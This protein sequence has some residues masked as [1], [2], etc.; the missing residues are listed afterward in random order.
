MTGLAH[1]IRFHVVFV[2]LSDDLKTWEMYL[3][4][5]APQLGETIRI[6]QSNRRYR[7]VGFENGL[8]VPV[9]DTQDGRP[10]MGFYDTI[11]IEIEEA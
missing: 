8:T 11:T 7:V 3:E 1:T 2:N 6:N 5:R 4:H 9:E 10:T